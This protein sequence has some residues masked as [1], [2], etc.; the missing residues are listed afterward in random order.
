MYEAR[1]ILFYRLIL[2]FRGEVRDFSSIKCSRFLP[3]PIFLMFPFFS[4]FQSA[5]DTRFRFAR[6]SE[7]VRDEYNGKIR[8]EPIRAFEFAPKKFR[9]PANLFCQPKLPVQV[10]LAIF[11]QIPRWKS[12]GYSR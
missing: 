1:V 4:Y 3:N 6:Q 11:Q 9:V 5:K 10:R 7:F 12:S 8:Q 2:Q